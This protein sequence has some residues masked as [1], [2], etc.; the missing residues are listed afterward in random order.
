MRHPRFVAVL[1]ALAALG[2]Y[3]TGARPVQAQQQAIPV[4]L[5]EVVLFSF[6]DGRS[7]ECRIEEVRGA[8]A[9]CGEPSD[10]RGSAIGRPTRRE[11]P[12]Q[13]VNVGV[14]EWVTK[15]REER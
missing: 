9:R 10:R 12:E 6:Q 8:F 1:V 3:A 4:L 13:W 5:G 7:R 2:G 11:P 15:A 14:V